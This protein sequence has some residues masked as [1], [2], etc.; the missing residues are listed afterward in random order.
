MTALHTYLE[1]LAETYNRPNF[2]ADDPIQI[3]HRFSKPQDIE[4]TAFWTAILA[5]GQRKTI[6]AKATELFERMD[7][8]PHDFI[9]NHT[10]TER[11]RFLNFKHRT[12]QP[13]DTLFF[14]HVLQTHYRAHSSLETAFTAHLSP[15]D[16]TIENALCG[17]YTYFFESL[18]PEMARTRKHIA[19]PA[20]GSACK[21]LCMLLRWL[22]R[23]DE[24]GVDFGLWQTVRMSQLVLPLDVHVERQARQLGLLTRPKTDWQAALELTAALRLFCPDDPA[25]Y[26]FALFGLGVNTAKG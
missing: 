25:K 24:N 21:R 20:R 16:E 12:F 1:S 17:F 3:P 7:G 5:W 4:I 26:D 23:R 6:M 10:E 22:V 9:V 19:S 13:D 14:L 2:I 11:Q 18:P 15:D 8:A